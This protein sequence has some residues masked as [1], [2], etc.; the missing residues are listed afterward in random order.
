MDFVE[1][2]ALKELKMSKWKFEINEVNDYSE[3]LTKTMDGM[4][5]KGFKRLNENGLNQI[6]LRMRDHI[7]SSINDLKHDD[8]EIALNRIKFKNK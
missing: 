2:N 3:L 7:E 1:K 5:N 6:K 4:E 8:R